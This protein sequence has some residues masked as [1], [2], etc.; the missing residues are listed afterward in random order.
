MRATFFGHKN[1]LPEIAS[2]LESTLIHLIENDGVNTFYIGN[3][4]SFDSIVRRTL[5]KL[6]QSYPQINYTVVLAYMPGSKQNAGDTSDT[7]YPEGLENTPP[8]YAIAK[9]NRWLIEHSDIVITYVR[10]PFGGAAQYKELAEKKGKRV[11]NLA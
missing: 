7:I 10:H 1:T 2:K 11:I 4:G 8:K 6:Q 3:Q 9:R 5:K